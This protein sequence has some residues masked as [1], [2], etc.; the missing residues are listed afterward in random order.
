MIFWT[1]LGSLTGLAAVILT[2]VIGLDRDHEVR[3][4]NGPTASAGTTPATP[5]AGRSP[6]A[7]PSPPG[8]SATALCDWVT[9]DPHRCG[10]VDP[11]LETLEYLDLSMPAASLRLDDGFAE[12]DHL[13]Y[14][15]FTSQARADDFLNST[16]FAVRFNE[17]EGD[18]T[19]QD[20]ALDAWWSP[21][22]VESGPART[23]QGRVERY[24]WAEYPV[25]MW[26][27]RRGSEDFGDGPQGY[28]VAMAVAPATPGS[29][30]ELI[31]WWE[32]HRRPR[33]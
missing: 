16:L 22:T 11:G 6:S 30:D 19:A 12:V 28:V 32:G 23:T 9:A 17:D 25:V 33:W 15:S 18:A 24:F 10:E 14:F 3:A 29:S 20:Y 27:F 2:L 8:T 5:D 13:M 26:S 4:D 21:A 31:T 1:A 7:E